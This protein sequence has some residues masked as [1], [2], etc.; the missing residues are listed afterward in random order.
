VR[1]NRT[2]H[3]EGELR[4]N[5]ADLVGADLPQDF[6]TR[7]LVH[8]L[9]EIFYQLG[10]AYALSAIDPGFRTR[11][12]EQAVSVEPARVRGRGFIDGVAARSES[13][14]V[15]GIDWR[16]KRH[17]L[18]GALERIE[19]PLVK[20]RRLLEEAL[21]VEDDYEPA[22]LYLA[23]LDAREGRTLKAAKGYRAIFDTAVD[24]GNRGHAAVQL[25][26]LHTAEG[27]FREALTWF[28]WVGLSGLADLDRRFFFARFNVG[29][30]YAHLRQPERALEAF[31]GMLDRH[32]E[33]VG[34]LVSF[35]ARS[36]ELRAAIDAQPGFT[37]ALAARCPELFQSANGEEGGAR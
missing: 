35:F 6:E 31:R 20:A 15:G 18:N 12:F 19:Q 27:E 28:R 13:G 37:E 7:Q 1:L 34:E 26:V 30:C 36:P 32:P 33:R 8:R 24:P 9:A 29:L 23:F 11:I 14:T 25:G 16:T 17:L 2:L 5:Y 10:K 22:Q 3:D 21:A 4:R